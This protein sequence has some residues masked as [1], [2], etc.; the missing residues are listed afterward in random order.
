MPPV[1]WGAP[2]EQINTRARGTPSQVTTTSPLTSLAPSSRKGVSVAKLKLPG[3]GEGGMSDQKIERRKSV[4]DIV[5]E[6]E[7]QIFTKKGS[8][9]D[10]AGRLQPMCKPD[11]VADMLPETENDGRECEITL[12]MD[13]E[14][15]LRKLSANLT[16]K[17]W[18]MAKICLNVIDEQE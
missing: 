1:W 14:R 18:E 12:S 7:G 3:V 15:I 6:M 5:K 13:E 4:G 11:S 9:C 17:K 2:P 16:N 10:V 8:S